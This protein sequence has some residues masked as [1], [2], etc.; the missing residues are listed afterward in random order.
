MGRRGTDLALRDTSPA[1][2]RRL[3]VE[4]FAR[5]TA[6]RNE[7]TRGAIRRLAHTLDTGQRYEVA[8]AVAQLASELQSRSAVLAELVPAV[9]AEGGVSSTLRSTHRTYDDLASEAEGLATAIAASGLD[10]ELRARVTDLERRAKSAMDAER[11][12]WLDAYWVD[13][14]VGD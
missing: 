9:E 1:R 13:L 11:D 10:D 14:G 12:G 8:T 7:L 6:R 4:P 5:W 2:A 3:A